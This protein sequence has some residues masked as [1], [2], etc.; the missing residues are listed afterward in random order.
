MNGRT[1]PDAAPSRAAR[2]GRHDA[3]FAHEDGFF[4]PSLRP[5]P[6]RERHRGTEPR[7]RSTPMTTHAT[8]EPV[9]RY[10]V[11][12]GILVGLFAIPALL[13]VLAVLLA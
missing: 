11:E 7:K 5:Y 4:T 1:D 9:G 3:V 2:Y 12:A 8:S 13:H 6:Y 10:T